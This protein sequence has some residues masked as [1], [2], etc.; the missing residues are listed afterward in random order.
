MFGDRYGFQPLPTCISV[1]EMD[2]ILEVCHTCEVSN[3]DLLDDWY[4]LDNNAT[5]P[6]YELQVRLS[7]R[8][9]QV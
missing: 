4:L 3:A 9:V 8:E 2:V 5:P 6:V 1:E 7:R